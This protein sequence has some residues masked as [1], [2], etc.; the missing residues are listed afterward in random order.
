MSTATKIEW[1]RCDGTAG[2]TWNP[3]TGARSCPRGEALQR[4][5]A[6]EVMSVCREDA[7]TAADV[8]A[9]GFPQMTL[10]QFVSLFCR[11][12]S[13]CGPGTEVTRIEWRYLD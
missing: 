1:T 2:A 13:G 11:T 6:V 3:V 12:H 10:A 8:A 7:I 5:A 9:E 4:I